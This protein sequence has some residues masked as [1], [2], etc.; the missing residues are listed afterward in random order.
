MRIDSFSQEV[1]DRLARERNATEQGMNEYLNM[2]PEGLWNA[3]LNQFEKEYLEWQKE[4]YQDKKLEAPD[5][6]PKKRIRVRNLSLRSERV[7]EGDEI[8]V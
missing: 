8:S 2:T 3:D 7:A 5:L 1:L 4:W 6:K